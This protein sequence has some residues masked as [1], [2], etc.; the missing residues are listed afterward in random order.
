MGMISRNGSRPSIKGP[1][2]NFIGSVRVDP[3]FQVPAPGRATGGLV[4]FEPEHA[5]I[6]IR[7]PAARH[8]LSSLVSAGPSAGVNPSRKSAQVM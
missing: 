6:G 4:T 5:A 8:S 1:T 2:D 7:I 3:L